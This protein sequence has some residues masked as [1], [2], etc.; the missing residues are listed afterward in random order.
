[1][2]LIQA[3]ITFV[4]GSKIVRAEGAV[5]KKTREN[6]IVVETID[7]KEGTRA[8]MMFHTRKEYDSYADSIINA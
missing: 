4:V 3:P 1:M 5:D 6:L 8:F 2:A 7:T